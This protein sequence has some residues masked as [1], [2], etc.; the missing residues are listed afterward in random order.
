MV[1]SFSVVVELS[2]AHDSV[3]FGAWELAFYSK[4]GVEVAAMIPATAPPGVA[5]LTEL[6]SVTADWLI[7]ISA[8]AQ[9]RDRAE[10][11]QVI[12]LDAN[13]ESCEHA[14]ED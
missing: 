11:A 2:T 4:L 12:G 1:T 8:P 5:E 3:C 13:E 7:L 10:L 6:P 14:F 9:D